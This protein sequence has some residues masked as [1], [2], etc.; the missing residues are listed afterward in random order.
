MC[1]CIQP[2]SLHSVEPLLST[3]TTASLFWYVSSS[4]AHL[5]GEIFGMFSLQDN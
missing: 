5:E 4:F 3:L 1:I 2:M